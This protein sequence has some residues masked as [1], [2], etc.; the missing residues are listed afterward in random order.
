MECVK[1][2]HPREQPLDAGT[3]LMETSEKK[4]EDGS[5]LELKCDVSG[6]EFVGTPTYFLSLKSEL[7]QGA[8]KREAFI[9]RPE[10]ALLS[11]AAYRM[12]MGRINSQ[13]D[14]Y[15]LREEICADVEGLREKLHELE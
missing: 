9:T 5:V 15:K 7:G 4:L 1:F 3:I 13:E 6:L 10:S 14:F 8:S 2:Y 11:E 12:V